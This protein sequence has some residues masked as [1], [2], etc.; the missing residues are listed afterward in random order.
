[1]LNELLKKIGHEPTR[2]ALHRTAYR[3][4]FNVNE[5]TPSFFT[6]KNERW[7][8]RDLLKEYNYKDNSSGLGG[9]IFHFV[10]NYFNISFVEAKRKISEI[11][12]TENLVYSPSAFS[13]NQ[14]KKEATYNVVKTQSLQNKS[15][16]HYLKKDR[17]L[18]SINLSKYVSEVYYQIENKSYF[19]VS[20]TNDKGGR[21]VRNKYFKGSFGKKSIST[22]FPTPSDNRVKIFEGFIDFLSYLQINKNAPLSNYLILNSVSLKEDG[23]KAIQNKFS[24]FELYLDNDESGDRATQFFISNLANTIDK[25]V[26]YK[27]CKDLNNFLIQKLFSR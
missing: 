15:L 12:D 26:H 7:D 27:Q 9:D 11:L 2:V 10:M 5:K 16:I 23:L 18:A 25:R 14:P 22:I 17:G 21:E 3:S 6:F 19:A 13:F 20:F 24:S 4:P 8:G 1:M